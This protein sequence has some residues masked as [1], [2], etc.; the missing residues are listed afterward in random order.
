MANF[1][2]NSIFSKIQDERIIDFSNETLVLP[3]F[4]QNMKEKNILLYAGDEKNDLK[5]S[6]FGW[7]IFCCLPHP[8]NQGWLQENLDFLQQNPDL[9]II[10]CLI[11]LD[12]IIEITNF[13]SLFEESIDIIKSDWGIIFIPE[14]IVWLLLKPNGFCFIMEDQI[15]MAEKYYKKMRTRNKIQYYNYHKYLEYSNFTNIAKWDIKKYD[16]K[17]Y[18]CTKIFNPVYYRLNG[19]LKGGTKKN[20]CL[21]NLKKINY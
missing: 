4:Y 3:S 12:N 11:N 1:R 6:E 21:K 19:K 10:L 8:D 14:K 20:I 13:S 2:K 9:Q 7:N 5:K 15:N 16:S 18:K 17:Y